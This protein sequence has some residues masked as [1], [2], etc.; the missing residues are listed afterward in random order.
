[1]AQSEVEKSFGRCTVNPKFLDRFYE[2]FLA[3]H[4]TIGPMFAHTNM[5]RQ[6]GLLR[7]G[8]TMV[9]MHAQGNSFGTR[10]LDKIAESHSKKNWN[11]NPSLYPFWVN[12]L[13]QT[14]REVA[15]QMSPA[16]E[17]EWRKTLEA[18]VNY[19]AAGYNKT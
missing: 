14:I 2:I 5:A 15:P 3:S 12:S 13:I 19:I 1:M 11:I 10:S 9:V 18:G 6:K 7:A 4:P 8:L 16:L 17:A